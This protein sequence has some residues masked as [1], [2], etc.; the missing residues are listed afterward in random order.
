MH[1]IE[2][3]LD[4]PLLIGFSTLYLLILVSTMDLVILGLS[5]EGLSLL[6]YILMTYNYNWEFGLEASIKYFS[7]GGIMSAIN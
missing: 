1:K 3:I 2:S 4:F 5:M 7:L 6:L